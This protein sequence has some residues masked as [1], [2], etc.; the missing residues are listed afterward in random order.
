MYEI[1]GIQF[2]DEAAEAP[3]WSQSSYVAGWCCAGRGGSPF[4]LKCMR[5]VSRRIHY[6]T[7]VDSSW[8]DRRMFQLKKGLVL[9][10]SF[11]PFYVLASCVLTYF[12]A[13]TVLCRVYRGGH[14]TIRLALSGCTNRPFYRIVAA[15]NKRPRDGRFVEQ[16]GSY[17]PLPN[18][19]G[20]K[21]V[22]LNLDRIRHWMGC[23]AHLSKPVE[24]LLGNSALALLHWGDCKLRSV[25]GW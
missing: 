20:E 25:S 23:G 17:D 15:H 12:S 13:A 9:S 1:N 7:R 3:S 6:L 19:H 18:S 8:L 14:L 4:W 11:C 24:K 5:G 22:A 21:I 16:L 10:T 2:I